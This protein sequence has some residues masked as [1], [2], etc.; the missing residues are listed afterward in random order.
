MLNSSTTRFARRKNSHMKK[1]IFFISVLAISG[2]VIAF[3]ARAQESVSEAPDQVEA[4]IQQEEVNTRDLGIENP[5]ILPTSP[6]YFLKEWRRG[7]K[8]IFTFNAVKKA[9]LELQ[10]TNE[11]AAEIKKLEEIAPSNIEAITK[12]ANNYQKNMERLKSRLES[13]KETSQNPNVDK[14]L[15]NLVKRS[16]QHQQLFE[17]LKTKFE[18]K[19][20]LK[21]QL[22]AGQEKINEIIAKIPE[23]FEDATAFKQRLEK[24]IESLPGG[25]FKELRLVEVIE[26][27]KEKLPEAQREKIQE[28]K[29]KLIEKLEGVKENLNPEIQ[30]K[31]EEVKEKIL[32]SKTQKPT[33]EIEKEYKN[34]AVNS[35]NCQ[36][37]EGYNFKVIEMGWGPCPAGLSD[38]PASTLKCVK[39]ETVPAVKPSE[40]KVCIQVITPALSPNGVCKEFPTPCDVPSGWQKVDRCPTPSSAT[41]CG[42]LRGLLCPLGYVCQLEGNYPDASGKCV[43]ESSTKLP[44]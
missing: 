40:G 6:F 9:E 17:N 38:C 11:R 33:C 31:I 1:I 29:D 16:L 44:Q 39:S 42:G 5:G 2:W 10:E 43:L 35:V 22:K 23:K 18:E 15:D 24:T 19:T 36:C 14:L 3:P 7:I 20:E 28:L 41:F 13:L 27:I 21:E 34:T 25:V 12:A 4:A 32:E 8:K 30:K 26:Q 37:P